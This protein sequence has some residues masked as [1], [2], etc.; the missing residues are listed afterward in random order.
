MGHHSVLL[1][2]LT[3]WIFFKSFSSRVQIML[4]LASPTPP[5][6]KHLPGFSN[7]LTSSQLS[8]SHS[9]TIPSSLL[10]S[11]KAPFKRDDYL[12]MQTAE[13]S[14]KNNRLMVLFLDFPYSRLG[15]FKSCRH[16]SGACP[17][18]A[19]TARRRLALG[20]RPMEAREAFLPPPSL[21]CSH[22]TLPGSRH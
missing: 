1:L 16:R 7:V 22:S 6:T 14:R 9:L 2:T 3:L 4:R 21:L 20:V 5:Q 19:G 17:P 18:K 12:K 11:P 10:D 15:S 8:A 13:L